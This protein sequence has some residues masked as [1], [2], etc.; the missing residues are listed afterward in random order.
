MHSGLGWVKVLFRLVQCSYRK[1]TPLRLIT[2]QVFTI[3][4]QPLIQTC[5]CVSRMLDV[6]SDFQ[7]WRFLTTI[8]ISGLTDHV[9]QTFKLQVR[10]VTRREFPPQPHNKMGNSLLHDLGLDKVDIMMSPPCLHLVQLEHTDYW[11]VHVS[12]LSSVFTTTTTTVISH[13]HS[14]PTLMK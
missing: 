11:C 12:K 4:F 7:C 5:V 14:G 9:F 1:I 13:F 6:I 8:G 2:K 10:Q 3:P